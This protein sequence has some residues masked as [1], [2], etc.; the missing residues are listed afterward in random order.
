MIPILFA[1]AIHVV[2]GILMSVT[3]VFLML[4]VLVQRGRGGGL[5]GAFGGA[6]GQSAF[7]TK[8]G[9]LFTRITICVAA[10]W[11]VLCLVALRVLGT[12]TSLFGT[13]KS[14][15][16]AEGLVNPGGDGGE[17]AA[18]DTGAAPTDGLGSGSGTSTGEG[19]GAGEPKS[20]GAVP[21]EN[22]K[23]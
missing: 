9:D 8:A 14:T 6:G 1:S 4:I 16:A 12:T 23:D 7:G 15:P 5:A 19:A 22:K 18:G 17:D 13:E 20:S 3:A 21:E 2:F 10:F 11:I